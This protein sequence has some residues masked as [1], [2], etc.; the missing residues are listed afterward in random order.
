MPLYLYP[1]D[2]LFLRILCLVSIRPTF[3]LGYAECEPG[4]GDQIQLELKL[5]GLHTSV[6]KQ[7][8]FCGK[9]SVAFPAEIASVGVLFSLRPPGNHGYIFRR[10]ISKNS[11]CPTGGR[12]LVFGSVAGKLMVAQLDNAAVSAGVLVP[13]N[14]ADRT[15]YNPRYALTQR[16]TLVMCTHLSATGGRLNVEL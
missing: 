8:P 13:R 2:L 3:P 7:P 14:K 9:Q 12:S 16:G 6:L 15:S 1:F 11:A 10:D 5:A 4:L